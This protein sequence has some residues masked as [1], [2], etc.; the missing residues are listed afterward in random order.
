MLQHCVLMMIAKNEGRG[1]G[2]SGEGGML[3]YKESLYKESLVIEPYASRMASK[4][5]QSS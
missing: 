3:Y 5:L 4:V 1:G 2:G